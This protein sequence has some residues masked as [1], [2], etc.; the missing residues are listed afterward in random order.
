MSK[1]EIDLPF[2]EIRVTVGDSPPDEDTQRKERFEE[3][4]LEGLPSTKKT[5]GL[6][7]PFRYAQKKRQDDI[8][9]FARFSWWNRRKTKADKT[10]AK[11]LKRELARLKKTE[12]SIAIV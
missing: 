9:K 4:M 3:G 6:D 8:N 2:E 10:K 5:F 1:K 7:L 11:Q 12:P